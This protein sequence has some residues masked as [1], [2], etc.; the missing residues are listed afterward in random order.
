MLANGGSL[1]GVRI[2]SPF[3]INLM[4]INHLN[5][6]QLTDFSNGQHQ[7]YGY[8]LGVRVMIDPAAGG[9]NSTVGEFGWAGM[10][11]SWVLIDP[12]E[13]LSIVY[14]QQMLPSLEPYFHNRLKTVVYGSLDTI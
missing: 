1:N 6:E 7:G 4:R 11:G 2:L 12:K 8:G 14:M 13:K 3:T 9:S 5:S 10:A